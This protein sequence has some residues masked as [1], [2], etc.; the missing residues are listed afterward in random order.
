[1][2]PCFIIF[3]MLPDMYVDANEELQSWI[4]SE[5]LL[6]EVVFGKYLDFMISKEV[7]LGM[8]SSWLMSPFLFLFVLS[9]VKN[10]ENSLMPGKFNLN[11]SWMSYSFTLPFCDTLSSMIFG[12]SFVVGLHLSLDTLEPFKHERM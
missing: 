10:N 11:V 8:L 2:T 5:L 1:M 3:E 12:A 4:E 6:S 9:I 7:S